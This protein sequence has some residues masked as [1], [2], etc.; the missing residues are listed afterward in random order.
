MIPKVIYM[1]HKYLDKI[2]NYSQNWKLLNPEYEIKLYDDAMCVQFLLQYYS[3]LHAKI[4][5]FIKDGPI[6][7]DFWRVCIINT[8][9]G[10][11]VDA[12]IEPLCPLEE[13]IEDDDEFVTCISSNFYNTKTEW[14]LNPH[15]IMSYKNNNILQKCIDQ[16]INY[17]NNKKP[18]KYWD[19]SVC[20]IFYIANVKDKKSQIIY[21]TGKK[22]KFL[23]ELANG[24]DC[25][26]NGTIVLHNRY[27]NYVNHNFK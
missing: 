1:S 22:H 9:G 7:C 25:E 15:F 14:N 4:F 3:P 10:L 2:T 8:F 27:S 11:Y 12:D 17:Y 24:N 16:Y 19:W 23:L 18:Y 26:Y 20:R 13:Y 21:V 5:N 6:K